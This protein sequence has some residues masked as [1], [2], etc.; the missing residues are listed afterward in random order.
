MELAHGPILVHSESLF[1]NSFIS[2]LTVYLCKFLQHKTA[3]LLL[4]IATFNI[5]QNINVLQHL[6][7]IKVGQFP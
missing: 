1:F 4:T 2:S 7:D 5:N 3:M 6:E